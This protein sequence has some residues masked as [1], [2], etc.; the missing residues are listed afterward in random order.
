MSEVFRALGDDTRLRLLHLFL[1]R[2]LELCVCEMV[3]A[4]G[5]PQYQVSRHLSVLKRAGLLRAAKKGTWAY[6][7][8]AREET[9]I[10]NLLKLLKGAFPEGLFEEDGKRM[11]A[12]LALRAR[13]E[14]VIGFVG[15]EEI[16]K[17]LGGR[18]Q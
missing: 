18:V 5:L 8:L 13:G 10:R 9:F 4:L 16:N 2:N 1:E 12:R 7:S 15:V 6:Y 14:C 3:S 17:P 11:E